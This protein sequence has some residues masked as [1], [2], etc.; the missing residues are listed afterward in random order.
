[1]ARGPRKEKKLLR[2]PE[3][4]GGGVGGWVVVGVVVR[5]PQVGVRLCHPSGVGHA[6]VGLG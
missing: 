2:G 1:M 5:G 4:V 3:L 6:W